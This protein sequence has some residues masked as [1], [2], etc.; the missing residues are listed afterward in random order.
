MK[1]FTLCTLLYVVTFTG[2]SQ[3]VPLVPYLASNT[4]EEYGRVFAYENID[5]VIVSIGF[6]SYNKNE[7]ILE[8][9]I[10]NQSDDTI[11]FDPAE[12]YAFRD[13]ENFTVIDDQLYF[14]V[15]PE[16]EL[17]SIYQT[18]M[19]EEQI[20]KDTKKASIVLG[21][22]YVAAEIAGIS[23]DASYNTMEFVRGAHDL[24][25]FGLAVSR[26]EARNKLCNI[27]HYE[28]YWVNGALRTTI[29]PP[30][31]YDSGK[32]HFRIPKAEIYKIFLPVEDRIYRFGFI[33]DI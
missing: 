8:L 7:F 33:K 25:Q 19:V 32:L 9:T 20:I 15:N 28:D 31:K 17:D 21:I 30:G 24:A 14:A 1:T 16:V 23:S 29:I 22:V 11:F 18:A 6:E 4:F 5:D 12:V 13:W 2:F 10:D 26:E 3:A 27:Y